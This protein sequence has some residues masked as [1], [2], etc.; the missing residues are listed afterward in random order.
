MV[1]LWMVLTSSFGSLVQV[2]ELP[3]SPDA[4]GCSGLL[5]VRLPR[6]AQV[7]LITSGDSHLRFKPT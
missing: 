5:L 7:G 3:N 1:V 2:D 4:F 6:K